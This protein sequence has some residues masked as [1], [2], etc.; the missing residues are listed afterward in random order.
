MALFYREK[1][2]AKAK[3]RLKVDSWLTNW[4]ETWKVSIPCFQEGED[5]EKEGSSEGSG[6]SSSLNGSS[7]EVPAVISVDSEK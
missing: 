2:D 4:F 1:N 7:V 5:E 6:S 3:V